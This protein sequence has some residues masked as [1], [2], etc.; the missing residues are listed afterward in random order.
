[1]S[2]VTNSDLPEQDAGSRLSLAHASAMLEVVLQNLRGQGG[3]KAPALLL[4][5]DQAN[6]FT[7]T[8]NFRGCKTCNLSR[9]HEADLKLCIRMQQ[10]LRME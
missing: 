10:L 8:D 2:K 5:F 7:A 6:D 9:Q 3:R 1:M 4:R